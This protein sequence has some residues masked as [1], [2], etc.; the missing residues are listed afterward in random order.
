[1]LPRRRSDEPGQPAGQGRRPL[2][3]R[4]EREAT[5]L[6]IVD[7]AREIRRAIDAGVAVVERLPGR[8]PAPLGGGQRAPRDRLR[9]R[10]RARSSSARPSSPSSPSASGPTGSSRSSVTPR[11][12]L[13]ELVLPRR[14]AGRRRRGRREAGQP[15]RGPAD[16]PTAPGADAVIAAVAADRPVQS[17][18]DP[19]ERSARSSRCPSSRPP[20]PTT[21]AWLADRGVRDR[22]RPRRRRAPTTPTVDLR[23]PLAIV[24]G[25]EA[26]GLGATWRRPDVARGPPADARRRRQPQRL[27]R[28]G[29]PVL[30]GAPPARAVGRP[31]R[32]TMSDHGHLRLRDHR[33]RSGRRGR[34]I[35]GARARRDASRS[36]IGDWFG[37]SCPHIGCLPSKS[38]L[39]AAARHAANPAT[40][41]W[42]RASARRDYMV[43]RPAGRRRAGRLQPR[44]RRSRTPARSPI[45]APAGS[46]V[47][48]GSRSRHDG[49]DH[50]LGGRERG[51][52]G[53]LDVEGAAD[54]GHR[55]RS[56]T[57][58]NREATLTR[59]LPQSLLV[60]GGG[61]TGCELAQVYARFGVP[62]TIVQSG[63][64]LMPTDHPA[65]LGG[66][67]R[68]ARRATA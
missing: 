43:N 45:A 8:G 51:R 56:R 11:L 33:R 55:R 53:R 6:T 59:E 14:P 29:H 46:S 7:G 5:G 34:R 39:D 26:D 54:R 22:R 47:A 12:D 28:R 17:E 38:L 48:A 42:A 65:Q 67:P 52:R 31:D 61:P 16:R 21:L 30:R 10:P 20:R 63:P 58:T 68:R 41:D 15:R 4:R 62:T 24:L 35:Q 49:A 37:G 40:Y 50:E 18:R 64:R 13:A 1:M 19:G 36:S 9:H 66:G 23:G 27:G 2:R 57:W 3:D 25:A 44:R 32:G 60:L